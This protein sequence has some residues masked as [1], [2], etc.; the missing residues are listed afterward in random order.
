MTYVD[1]QC[2]W[3]GVWFKRKLAYFKRSG[4]HAFCSQRCT[5]LRRR[6]HKSDAE[7]KSEKR[8]YDAAYRQKNAE[9]IKALK[10]AHFQNTYDPEKARVERKKRMPYH[11]EYLR[12]R[13]Q[14]PAYRK[15]K[16]DYDI[17]RRAKIHYGPFADCDLILRE[18]Q[19]AV[20]ARMTDYEIR[21]QQ[22]T[23]NKNQN[24]KRKLYEQTR[25]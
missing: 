23:L 7:K 18:I 10:H 19:N 3:C 16:V 9:R 17:K 25:R 1:L 13:M 2:E 21:L 24:R 14:D 5:G 11:V 20:D 15:A 8:D 22:G 12:R 4:P 6:Q